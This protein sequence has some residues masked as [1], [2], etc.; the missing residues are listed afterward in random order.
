MGVTWL[1]IVRFI[2]GLGE[3]PIVSFFFISCAFYFNK[4]FLIN[5]QSYIGAMYARS[6]SE[7]DSSKW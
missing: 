5:Y 4:K 3:G 1:I 6:F 2:Q 7:M